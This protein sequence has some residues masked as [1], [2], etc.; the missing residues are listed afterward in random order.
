MV[1][2][3]QGASSKMALVKKCTEQ[4]TLSPSA[5]TPKGQPSGL[6]PRSVRHEAAKFRGRKSAPKLPKL[7]NIGTRVAS[8]IKHHSGAVPRPIFERCGNA[9]GAPDVPKT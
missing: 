1:L 4:P 7:T 9:R 6:K 3:V 5:D 2:A 8:P